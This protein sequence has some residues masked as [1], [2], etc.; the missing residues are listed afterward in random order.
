MHSAVSGEAVK[1]RPDKVCAIC[2]LSERQTPS[3]G[4][5]GRPEK[6]QDVSLCLHFLYLSC[7]RTSMHMHVLDNVINVSM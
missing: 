4:L 2:R 7:V 3:G 5:C 6:L 1:G